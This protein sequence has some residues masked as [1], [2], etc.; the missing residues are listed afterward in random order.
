M[1]G[2]F[3]LAALTEGISRVRH[4]LFKK[5]RSASQD[6]HSKYSLLQT[7]LHGLH[8]LM[9]YML[10]LAT[11][12]FSL[13]LFFSVILGLVFGYVLFGGDEQTHVAT[14]PCCAFLEDET[15]H[16]PTGTTFSS[17]TNNTNYSTMNSSAT[18][19][20]CD[21]TSTTNVDQIQNA[22]PTGAAVLSGATDDV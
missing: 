22:D 18:G 5:A 14:N 7:S 17:A 15:V 12:T 6:E 4:Q 19:S 1:L 16:Q 13:E 20:C 9:G 8:A 10:M 3:G 2:I 11:M 21:P